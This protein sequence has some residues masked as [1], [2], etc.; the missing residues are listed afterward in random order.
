[1]SESGGFPNTLNT[2]KHNT[3]TNK[4]YQYDFFYTSFTLGILQQTKVFSGHTIHQIP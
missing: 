2:N 1:M 4:C 3:N